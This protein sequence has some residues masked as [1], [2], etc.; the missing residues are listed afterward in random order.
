MTKTYRL[1]LAGLIL[2][3]TLSTFAPPARGQILYAWGSNIYGQL[4][5]GTTTQRNLP[6]SVVTATGALAGKTV[7]A[8]AAGGGHSLALCS[9]GTLAAWGANSDGQLGNGS[10]TPSV[11]PVAVTMSG[12]LANKT[13]TAI[14]AGAAHS[15][16]LCSDG[17]VAAWG[18]NSYGELGNN[19]T[20]ASL[21]PVLVNTAGALA[22]KAV[23]AISAGR[24]H[25]L[26]LCS[27]G[28]VAAWGRNFFGQLGNNTTTDSLVPVLV[29]TGGTLAGKM[30]TVIVAG[31]SHNLALYSDG[32]LA[33]WGDNGSGQLG[34]SS[35]G[36]MGGY[37]ESLVP[38]AVTL[39]GALA[40]KTVVAIAAGELHSLALCSD[41]TVSAW[42]INAHGQ[43]EQNSTIAWLWE[44]GLVNTATGVSAL[45]GKTVT[46]IAAGSF[47]NL[48][49]CSDGTVA[50]WGYNVSGQIG[51]T[52][53]LQRYVPVAVN[54][55]TLAAGAHFTRVFSGP[56]AAHSLALAGEPPISA[57]EVE[58]TGLGNVILNNDLTP[59][60]S[61]NT[62]FGS[63]PVSGGAQTPPHTF[64]IHN[65]GNAPLNVTG[66]NLSGSNPSDFSPLNFTP[67]TIPGN[68]GT[69]TFDLSFDPSGP[70]LRT[71][72]VTISNNDS[73]EGN[74]LFKV[75]GFGTTPPQMIVRGETMVNIPNGDTTPT[76]ND[77]TAFFDAA[78]CGT[79]SVTHTFYIYNFGTDTLNLTGNPIV[80]LIGANP[81][82]FTV[83]SQPSA[84]QVLGG[85]GWLTFNVTFSPTAPG[86]RTATLSI[87]NDSS[88]ANPY[89]FAISGNGICNQTP[90]VLTC[91]T[92]KTVNCGTDWSFDPPTATDSCSGTTATIEITSTVTNATAIASQTA[93]TRT[94]QA[95]DACGNTNTCSQTVTLVDLPGPCTPRTYTLDADF[96]EGFSVNLNHTNVHEQLQ[97]N[98]KTSPFPYV[99]IAASERGTVVKIDSAT[100]SILGEYLSAPDGRGR[101]PSR[102]TV[103]KYG[104]CWIGNRVEGGGGKGS[105]TRYAI[106]I[107]GTRVNAAGNPDPNGQYLKPPFIYNSGAVDRDNDGLIKTSRGSGDI[108]PW[109]NLI[110]A[111]DNGGV[112]TADDE[113]IITYV[114]TAGSGVRAL[115]VDA[116]NDLWVGGKFNRVHEKYSG[117]DGTPI[118][119]TLFNIGIGGYGAVIDGNGTV[120]SSQG[121]YTGGGL[122]RLTPSPLGGIDL[123]VAE[124]N[125]GLSIDAC[126]N[127]VWHTTYNGSATPQ[128]NGA[129][130]S[131]YVRNPAGLVVGGPYGHGYPAA[132]GVCVD[133]SGNVFVAH[134][135]DVATNVGHLKIDGTFVGNVPLV[136]GTTNGV[137]PTGAGVDDSGKIW[138]SCYTSHHVMRIDPNLGPVGGGGFPIGAVDL[139]V[140]LNAFTYTPP[141]LQNVQGFPY[142]GPYNYSDQ[143]GFVILSTTA[144]GGWW[145]V[146]RDGGMNG[147]DWG[148]VSWHSTE[149]AGT[150]ITVEVR[151]DDNV[152]ALPSKPWAEVSSGTSF[153]GSGIAGRYLEIR[154]FLSKTNACAESPALLDLT[155]DCCTQTPCAPANQLPT[156]AGCPGPFSFPNSTA[157]ETVTMSA[158]FSDPDG[159]PLTV[160]WREGNNPPYQTDSVPAGAPAATSATLGFTHT[161]A[162]GNHVIVIAV[163]D[164]FG[165]RDVCDVIVKVGDHDRPMI[166]APAGISVAAFTGVI[167][168]FLA[169][170]I[171]VDDHTPPEKIALTQTPRAGLVVSQGVHVIELTARD[172]AGNTST[173]QTF[174]AVSPVVKITSPANY[175]TFTASATI[176]VSATIASNVPGVASVRLLNG[177]VVVGTDS[178][179]PYSF[180]L[181]NLPPGAYLLTLQAESTDNILSLSEGVIISVSGAGT[182]ARAAITGVALNGGNISFS[183]LT[184]PGSTCHVESTGT[185]SPPNW[186]V[187]RTIVGD[188]SIV[189]VTDSTTNA[190]QRFYRVRVEQP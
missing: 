163:N 118:A 10:T 26:A 172:L 184:K 137:G 158:T 103:D 17:T 71:A 23:I 181:N 14:A 176:N 126:S 114:R 135:F 124:G 141:P 146:V 190:P 84:N 170:P 86:L 40:N 104:N 13:V 39:S 37:G 9:D 178:T 47:H 182:P 30:V 120:W 116:N 66:I 188:G 131:V 4:G 44:P 98:A 121:P 129:V 187:L 27:D 93:I 33:A 49:L 136:W 150:S 87:A 123:G 89:E 133:Q 79:A 142:A 154:V 112:S 100:G 91:A 102:T 31:G 42:G 134:G 25:N 19:S 107:G 140:N 77:H 48:A 183:I 106:V 41:G 67:G 11:A 145:T 157:P 132:Q 138:V 55:S 20:A 5:D 24:S 117:L 45:A 119:G 128:A 151:A 180:A 162:P 36:I 152:L 54:T 149:P 111:D 165:N 127:L 161:F 72:F 143:T 2:S 34:S 88:N 94:W 177:G 169:G 32:T 90:P 7:T 185:L 38:V 153:C 21:V 125:Y 175:D 1:F 8:L 18:A 46:A 147:I 22:N 82:D 29:T 43:L 57:P 60:T 164:G 35:G 52:T 75:Q 50:A 115:A 76:G 16:A 156:V 58:V 51:D 173:G 105:V 74:C 69:M 186:V 59:T 56:S 85:G 113:A 155:A 139:V 6:T 166:T 68:G 95:T 70:G 171:A 99:W 15:L 160:T 28:A 174:F 168:N 61:D 63:F 81:G 97:V 109:S 179:A 80:N 122:L 62:D 110:L 3:L 65:L 96:D 12:V 130:G 148:T 53:T 189:T 108:L 101:N 167:P 83:T 78:V 92:N 64:V 144:P 73:D 159:D